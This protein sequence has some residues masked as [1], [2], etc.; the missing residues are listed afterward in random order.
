MSSIGKNKTHIPSLSTFFIGHRQHFRPFYFFST[1]SNIITALCLVYIIIPINVGPR[2]NRG[3]FKYP[4]IFSRKI[5]KRYCFMNSRPPTF[6][7]VTFKDS[8][9]PTSWLILVPNETENAQPYIQTT[10]WIPNNHLIS[11]HLVN[12]LKVWYADTIQITDYSTKKLLS[13]K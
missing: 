13:T 8:R 9:P 3:C 6:R 7:L 12:K 5:Q 4:P 10:I 1:F 11:D 2:I